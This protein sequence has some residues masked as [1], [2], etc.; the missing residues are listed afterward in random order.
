M[1]DF[2]YSKLYGLTNTDNIKGAL[3]LQWHIT[4]ECDQ[5]CKHCYMYDSSTYSSEKEEQLSLE[6]CYKLVDQFHDM[7]KKFDTYGSINIT[8]GDPILRQDFWKILKYINTKDRIQMTI[9]GNPYHITDNVAKKLKKMNVYSYQISIDGLEKTHDYF[10][11]EGSFKD[12]L[13]ALECLNRNGIYAK[14]MFTLSKRNKEELIEVYKYLSKFSFIDGFAFDR[15]VPIGSGSS[16]NSEDYLTAQ[17]HRDLL[18]KMYMCEINNDS[19]M[20]QTRKDEL[21]KLLLYQMGV[22]KPLPETNNKIFSGCGIAFGLLTVLADG[23]IYTCRRL[24]IGIGKF[25]QNDLC[26]TIINSKLLNDIIEIDNYD[27]CRECELVYFCRGCPAVKYGYNKDV[28]KS[29]PHCWK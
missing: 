2:S 27:K 10:R 8:G 17:E 19:G 29:D 15:L 4:A 21:W 5:H 25:P 9:L 6:N 14:V 3:T 22:S 12:S 28:F 11:K 24:D 23:T 7:V 13:R 26:N 18:Y 1:A 20:I 16:L